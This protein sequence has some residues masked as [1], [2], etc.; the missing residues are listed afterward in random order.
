MGFWTVGPVAGSL[1][2]SVVAT[3][4]IDHF[5]RTYGL[6]GW[7]SQ[8]IISGGISVLVFIVSLFFMK[9]LSKRLREQLMVSQQDRALVEARARGISEDEV[10]TATIHPWRQILKWDLV[11]SALGISV[12]LLLYYAASGFFTIFWATVYRDHTGLN[13]STSQANYLNIWFWSADAVALIV[14]GIIS[15]KLRVRKPLMLIGAV[16]SIVCLVLFARQTDHP[17]T[18]FGTLITL[19]VLMAACISL[20]YAPWMAGYTEMVEARNP[21]LV[22]TGLA[23]WGWILRL[24]V[25]LSF[26]FLPLVVTSVNPVVDNLAYAQ[27]FPGGTAPFNVQQ[28]QIDH[29]QLVTFATANASWLRP[30]SDPKNASVVAAAHFSPTA[31]NVTALQNAVGPAVVAKVLANL[32]EVNGPVWTYRT[33]LAYLSVHQNQLTSL[34]NGVGKSHS[35]WK[36]WFWVCVGGMVLFIPTIWL[37]RGRWSPKNARKDE[38]EHEADV[39]EELRQLVGANV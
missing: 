16:G 13:L 4:T 21:A 7:K 28:F 6:P 12:F 35:Q 38:L 3:N 18:G 11:G 26:I 22:G 9:D 8:F 10:V 29:P 39:A 1:L 30:L 24:T 5:L 14:F 31:A 2:T 33:Q 27:T 17:F 25:G 19:E 15:D 34:L 23:L 20:T 36:N 37:N 32:K